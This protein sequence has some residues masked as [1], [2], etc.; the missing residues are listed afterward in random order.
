MLR[1]SRFWRISG[2]FSIFFGPDP[3]DSFS[4]LSIFGPENCD[5][6]SLCLIHVILRM[7]KHIDSRTKY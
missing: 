5:I 3:G 4:S 6:V 1:L 2:D 7:F